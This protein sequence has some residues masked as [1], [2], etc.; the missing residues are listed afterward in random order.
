MFLIDLNGNYYEAEHNITGATEVPERPNE[1]CEWNGDVW[2]EDTLL[3]SEHQTQQTTSRLIGLVQKHLDVSAQNKGYDS[4][5]CACSY[6]SVPN[7]YQSEGIIFTQWRSEVWTK[8][9][10]ILNSVISG[11]VTVPTEAQLIAE[12]PVLSID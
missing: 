2:I 5:L 1:F 10:T 8:A 7:V 3:F 9:Y 6:A 12:L 4:I 11:T